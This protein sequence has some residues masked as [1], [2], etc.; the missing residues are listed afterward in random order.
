MRLSKTKHPRK[1]FQSVNHTCYRQIRSRSTNH[2]PLAW[3]KEGL[4]VTLVAVIG[5]FSIRSADNTQD[6]RKFWKHFLGCFA[7]QSH[8]STKMVIIIQLQSI[9]H[10]LPH[11]DFLF[12]TFINPFRFI[13]RNYIAQNA[14]SAAE[15]G[16]YSEVLYGFRYQNWRKKSSP[17]ENLEILAGISKDLRIT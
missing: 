13:L 2:S 7:F 8:I 3:H 12:F 6:W 15:K 1:R 11:L 14:I 10:F 17:P 16:D 4:K 5:G 9:F